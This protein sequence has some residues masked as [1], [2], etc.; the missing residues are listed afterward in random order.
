MDSVKIFL[1]RHGEVDFPRGI[2]YGQMDIPLSEKGRQQSL[3]AAG[4]AVRFGIDSV[5]SSDLERCAFLS[6]LIRD[7]GGPEP[8]YSREIREVDF[9]QWAGLGWDD[10]ERE[11]PGEMSRRMTDLE[12]YRPPGGECLG[13]VL[14]RAAK[15]F[16][17]CA[18]GTYGRAVAMVAHG[19]VNRVLIANFLGMKLQNIFNLH[20]DYTCINCIEIFSDGIGVLRFLNMTSHLGAL[21]ENSD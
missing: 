18:R 4:Q 17:D 10:I 2:F 21:A 20:Q 13:D 6:Q 19:G 11:Y 3:L 5:I 1:L 16:E 8:I 9:G 14:A 7:Q 15:V 12:N